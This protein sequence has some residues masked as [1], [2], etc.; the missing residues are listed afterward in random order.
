M[1]L[2]T[3]LEEELL[4]NPFLEETPS[5]ETKVKITAT[6]PPYQKKPSQEELDF[7]LSLI[8]KKMSLQ[9]ILLETGTFP[10]LTIHY[11]A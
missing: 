7:R 3:H 11:S 6:P 9:D 8:T 4:N 2:K 10:S 5:K 1:D